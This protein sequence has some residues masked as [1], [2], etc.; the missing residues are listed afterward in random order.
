MGLF[1]LTAVTVVR[2]IKETGIRMV[3]GAS[4]ADIFF[5]FTK[6]V[7]KLVLISNLIAWPIALV[8]ARNWLDQ[9]AYRIDIGI[10]MFALAAILSLLVAGSTVSWHAVRISLSDPVQSLRYE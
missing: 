5:L 4:A 1:G 8:A 10:W 9:F 3:L 2:R 7:L 6:D